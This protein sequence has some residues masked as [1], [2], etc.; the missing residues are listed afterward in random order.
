[1]ILSVT[2]WLIWKRRCTYKYD[3]TYINVSDLEKWIQKEII[4]HMNTL[5]LMKTFKNKKILTTM[6]ETFLKDNDKL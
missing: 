4:N 1:M 5:M 6:I 3:D 2:R